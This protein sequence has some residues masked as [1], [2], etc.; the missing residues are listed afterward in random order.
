MSDRKEYIQEIQSFLR[1]E[2]WEKSYSYCADKLSHVLSSIE[3]VVLKEEP[4]NYSQIS[5]FIIDMI[6]PFVDFKRDF[7]DKLQRL[8]YEW[9]PDAT[10]TEYWDNTINVRS[11]RINANIEGNRKDIARDIYYSHFPDEDPKAA[12]PEI[13]DKKKQYMEKVERLLEC[14][15]F[16]TKD[17]ESWQNLS[18]QD[19]LHRQYVEIFFADPI[20]K[21]LNIKLWDAYSLKLWNKTEEEIKNSIAEVMN[22]LSTKSEQ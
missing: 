18:A 9:N 10:I 16:Y 14:Y 8:R 12:T 5:D 15:C 6:E 4:S 17:E 13:I 11:K 1:Q 20:Q 19:Y 2:V 21:T 3:E 22:L 7:F